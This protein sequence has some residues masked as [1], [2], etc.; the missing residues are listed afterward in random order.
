MPT[1]G[2]SGGGGHPAGYSGGGWHGGYSEGYR[3]IKAL[4]AGEEVIKPPTK[5]EV[6]MPAYARRRG[7]PAVGPKRVMHGD[8]DRFG[9]M[10]TNRKSMIILNRMID[11]R[12]SDHGKARK[13]CERFLWA[14]ML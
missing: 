12:A 11:K 8:T 7:F 1:G 3:D 14:S 4:I 5:G 2:H 10:V 9:S 13:W 6:T